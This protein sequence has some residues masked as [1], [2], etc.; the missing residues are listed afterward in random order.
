LTVFL[1]ECSFGE[2]GKEPKRIAGRL[3]R[4]SNPQLSTRETEASTH[5]STQAE[6]PAASYDEAFQRSCLILSDGILD[7]SEEVDAGN[8]QPPRSKPKNASLNAS[9]VGKPN[10]PT[11]Y[12]ARAETRPTKY[13][14]LVRPPGFDLGQVCVLSSVRERNLQGEHADPIC[15]TGI[16]RRQHA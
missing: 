5:L 9:I 10:L 11:N 12:P 2:S 1:F 8:P 6:S 16:H 4:A 7:R 3:G 15:Q 14:K 13:G